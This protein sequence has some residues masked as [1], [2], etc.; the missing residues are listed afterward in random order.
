MVK[1]IIAAN[2]GWVIIF[3]F[4]NVIYEIR[5]RRKRKIWKNGGKTS[6]DMSDNIHKNHRKWKKF[7]YKL[8]G[9]INT[10]LLLFLLIS[11][12]III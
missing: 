12:L 9:L 8:F 10:V 4:E 2:I 1:L 5:V 11:Y 6:I 3:T 7:L